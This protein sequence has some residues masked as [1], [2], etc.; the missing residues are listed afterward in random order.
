MRIAPLTEPYEPDARQVLAKMM[1]P[2]VAPIALFRTFAN[3]LAMSQAMSTWGRYE[4]GRELSLSLRQREIVIDRVCARL[5]CEYEWGVHVAYFTDK[6]G[7]TEAQVRSLT[8]GNADDSCWDE[9]GERALIA[10]VDQLCAQAT[11]ADELWGQLAGHL[12][13]AQLLDLT[14]LAGWYHA[15]AFTARA[16]QVPLEEWAPRFGDYA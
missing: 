4:L 3:N 14:M 16:A 15:I 2:G 1:P 7:F 11:I 12:D 9:P 13:D 8:H 5:G 6:A 10:A